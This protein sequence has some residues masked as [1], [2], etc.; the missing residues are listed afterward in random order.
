MTDT[1]NTDT[2]KPGT[3]RINQDTVLDIEN[4]SQ[5]YYNSMLRDTVSKVSILVQDVK[6]LSDAVQEQTQRLQSIERTLQ[7]HSYTDLNDRAQKN[8][9]DLRAMQDQLGRVGK[10]T[11]DIEHRVDS[12]SKALG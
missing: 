5:G 6:E 12:I 3:N 9:S 8:T 11:L 1:T 10:K 2:T 4:N 7:G